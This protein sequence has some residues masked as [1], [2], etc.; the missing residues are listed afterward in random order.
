[1]GKQEIFLGFRGEAGQ[2]AR[3]VAG[4]ALTCLT[5]ELGLYPEVGGDD[6]GVDSGFPGDFPASQVW[7][8]E[9]AQLCG[10]PWKGIIWGVK[11]GRPDKIQGTYAQ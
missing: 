3:W 4:W 5:G 6:R 11:T 1:M 9:E 7:Q 2:A 10:S 8:P